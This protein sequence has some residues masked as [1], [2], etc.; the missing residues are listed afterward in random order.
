M[1]LTG[2]QYS[3]MFPS[4]TNLGAAERTYRRNQ[5]QISRLQNR[6]TFLDD[7]VGPRY[8]H[9]PLAAEEGRRAGWWERYD[10]K[11]RRKGTSKV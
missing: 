8:C 11:G 6:E 4:D 9:E 3:L 5:V 1:I 7:L 10:G 2:R